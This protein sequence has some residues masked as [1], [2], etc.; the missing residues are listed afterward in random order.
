MHGRQ[1][2]I[3]AAANILLGKPYSGL[4]V[5]PLPK[6]RDNI[7]L[8]RPTPLWSPEVPDRGG[9]VCLYCL[10]DTGDDKGRRPRYYDRKARLI[11]EVVVAATL[12]GDA[13]ADEIAEQIEGLLCRTD[14]LRDPTYVY[15]EG[16]SAANY[17]QKPMLDPANAALDFKYLDT[18]SVFVGER[19]ENVVI[20]TRIAFEGLFESQPDYEAADGIFDTMN[21]DYQLGG[22]NSTPEAT[23]RPINIYQE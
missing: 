8:N 19:V 14:W 11:A 20:S 23:D 16:D 9:A 17:V 6:V 21:V 12:G 5:Y 10:T 7:F 3:K 22:N 4:P 1:R 18:E 2:L 15:P 13:L